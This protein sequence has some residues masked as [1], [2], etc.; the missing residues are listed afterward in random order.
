MKDTYNKS[1]M[2]FFILSMAITLGFMFVIT[3]VVDGVQIKEVREGGAVQLA[4][5]ATS[6]ENPW[7]ASKDMIKHG[8]KLYKSN[9]ASCHGDRGLGDGMAGAA[10]N[11]RP[12]NLVGDSYKNGSD[13]V[14]IFKTLIVGIPGTSMA[15]YG[16]LQPADRWA[17]VHFVQSL[18]S[19]KQTVDDAKVQAFMSSAD[20]K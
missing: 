12:R 18:K 10:L 16:Y 17:I 6:V 14:G 19:D 15:A 20:Y 7:V 11:P 5:D 3:F 8:K 2:M 13:R 1:G 9:C 4:F